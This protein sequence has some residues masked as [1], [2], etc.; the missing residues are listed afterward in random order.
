MLNV[1]SDLAEKGNYAELKRRAE[2]RK[3]WQ[4]LESAES[5]NIYFSV[6]TG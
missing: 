3:G 1:L 4:K 2:D 6:E 5:H